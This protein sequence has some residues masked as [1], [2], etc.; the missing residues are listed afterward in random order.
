MN[1]WMDGW[2]DVECSMLNLDVGCS[3]LSVGCSMLSV[4]YLDVWFWMLDVEC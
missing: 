4:G 3:M 2:V 1:G